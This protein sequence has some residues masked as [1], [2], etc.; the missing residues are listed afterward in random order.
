MNR[1]GRPPRKRDNYIA[2]AQSLLLLVRA[3]QSDPALDPDTRD[4]ITGL[5]KM[6]AGAMINA[7]RSVPS[8]AARKGKR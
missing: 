6:A 7:K 2:D 8:P 1:T 3:V 4:G 5:L